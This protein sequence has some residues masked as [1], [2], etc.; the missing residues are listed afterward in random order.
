MKKK[1]TNGI[2]QFNSTAVNARTLLISAPV[3]TRSQSKM[4]ESIDG[5][6]GTNLNHFKPAHSSVF[7]E[8]KS[9]SIWRSAS[10]SNCANA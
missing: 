4:E 7:E 3:Q 8:S 2:V 10:G 6:N 5:M 9:P 1:K